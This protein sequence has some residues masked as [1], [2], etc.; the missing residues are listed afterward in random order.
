M[1]VT[2]LMCFASSLMAQNFSVEV[3]SYGNY[4]VLG[5]YFY[6]LSGDESVNDNDL[7]FREFAE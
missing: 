5:K 7:Q 3:D 1:V 6:V 2:I 4:D